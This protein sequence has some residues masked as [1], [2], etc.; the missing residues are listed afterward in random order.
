[1][2]FWCLTMVR[3][4]VA[5]ALLLLTGCGP[6]VVF[7]A[8]PDMSND[9]MLARATHVFVGVVRRQQFESWPFLGFSIP[10]ENAGRAKYWKL[11]RRDV[12]V[13]MVLRGKVTSKSLA[14]YEFSWTGGASGNWNN[15]NDGDRALFLLRVEN[16]R[17]HVVRDWWRSIFPI[18]TGPRAFLPLDE[19]HPLWER[20]ALMN[21]WVPTEANVHVSYPRFYY[22][23]PGNALGLW[24]T[25]KLQRGLV[26]H[27]SRDVRTAAC[28]DLVG[29]GGWGQDE[30]WTDLSPEDRVY[31]ADRYHC[32]TAKDIEDGRLN[33]QKLPASRFWS[34][35]K[36]LDERR[37]LT[38]VSNERR[39]REFCDLYLR[40]YPGDIENGCPADRRPPATVVTERGDVPLNSTSPE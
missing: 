8:A 38:T 39:R 3:Y 28:A 31:L 5:A 27:P 1:M 36:S 10:G 24:R 7:N 22:A 21:W 19:S 6:G 29:L 20:I 9:Q 18:T 32:C 15:L 37:L 40:Q 4:I 33:L 35:M 13:E 30:C 12:A 17:Y 34:S 25:A 11:L 26:R 23:D 14:V 16:G 2:P